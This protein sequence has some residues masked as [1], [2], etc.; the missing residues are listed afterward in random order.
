MLIACRNVESMNTTV[1]L[2]AVHVSEVR[3][4]GGNAEQRSGGWI[5][6]LDAA[7]IGLGHVISAKDRSPAHLVKQEAREGPSEEAEPEEGGVH[8]K[9]PRPEFGPYAL[10]PC[11]GLAPAICENDWLYKFELYELHAEQFATA[12]SSLALWRRRN[13]GYGLS[14]FIS[15]LGFLLGAAL[16]SGDLGK[17]GPMLLPIVRPELLTQ[18][19]TMEMVLKRSAVVWREG[20]EVLRP[21]PHVAAV[22]V[23]KDSGDLGMVVSCEFKHLAV[24]GDLLHG[25]QSKHIRQTCQI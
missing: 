15:S 25:A 18:D 6:V 11:A 8:Q 21:L 13:D 19:G 5:G 12:R 1:G 4:V 20:L 16:G 22:F 3:L 17:I 14:G 23:P 10:K 2:I 24:D 9:N 7:L